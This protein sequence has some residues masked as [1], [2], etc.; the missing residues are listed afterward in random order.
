[1]QRGKVICP[2]VILRKLAEPGFEPKRLGY[3]AYIFT[4]SL[5]ETPTELRAERWGWWG[6]GIGGVTCSE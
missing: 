1:M 4:E 3:R 2:K 5:R 6:G